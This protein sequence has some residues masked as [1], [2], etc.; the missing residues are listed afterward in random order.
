[1]TNFSEY[2]ILILIIIGEGLR[3]K[4]VLIVSHA[5]EIG[6]AEKALLGLLDCFDPAVY[7]VDLFL[8]HHSGELLGAIP[9]HVNLLPENKK[10]ASLSVPLRKVLSNGAPAV[11]LGRLYGKLKARRFTEKNNF[12]DPS[13]VNIEY[14]HKYTRRFLP[15]ISNTEYDLAVSFLTPHYFVA[16]K[17]RAKKKIAWI[18]TDYSFIETD[19]CSELKMWEPYYRI[20]SISE[21][22]GKAFSDKFPSLA[23]KLVLIENIHPADLIR[24]Q[25]EAFDVREE[26][27]DDGFIKL[28]SVGRYSIPKNFDNVPEICSLIPGVKWYIIGYG[29]DEAVVKQKIREFH[30]ED[31]VI[32]LGKKTNPYPYFKSCDYYV[33]PSRFEGNAV[34]VNEA[35]I[36]GKKVIVTN[37]R[38]AHDQINDGV[39]GIIVPLENKL[40]AE[41]IRAFLCNRELNDSISE[42]VAGTDFSKASGFSK[43]EQLMED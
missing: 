10:Y 25:S 6:G 4:K 31:R 7:C 17:V 11:G 5:M 34:T 12:S 36:L 33:Q 23:E 30:M 38:T 28:L 26:M 41:G 21:E 42:H 3:M 24:K 13:Y 40:C 2:D 37:Y 19:T 9:P 16:D 27:P 22:V 18:H 29:T 14:S 15:D 8:L 1:M 43:L 35:L 20:V 39:D 32:L